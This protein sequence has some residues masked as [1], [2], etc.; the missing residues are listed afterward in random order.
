MVPGMSRTGF[1][2]LLLIGLTLEQGRPLSADGPKKE[3]LVDQVR[4]AISRGVQYL[5]DQERGKGDWE[6]DTVG[7]NWPGGET[8][9]ALLLKK[10]S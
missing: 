2:A 5:R 1:L 3:H 8:S 9:L 6:L 10:G 7:T 4:N